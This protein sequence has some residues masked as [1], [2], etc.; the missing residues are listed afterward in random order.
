MTAI[1]IKKRR[2]ISPALFCCDSGAIRTNPEN[3]INIRIC[4]YIIHLVQKKTYKARPV[5]M[6][7]YKKK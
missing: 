7:K 2:N 5:Y 6:N 1:A 3:P 4:I